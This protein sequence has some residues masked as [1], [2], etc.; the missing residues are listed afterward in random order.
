[1]EDD[2]S[3]TAGTCESGQ[4]TYTEY[5][6]HRLIHS[7]YPLHISSNNQWTTD[8]P[9]VNMDESIP[10]EN[11]GNKQKNVQSLWSKTRGIETSVVLTVIL[12]C[13]K[14]G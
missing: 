12:A 1:M 4:R 8:K 2:G 13:G 3:D 14:Q 10:K 7:T 9:A 11:M 5:S 6:S